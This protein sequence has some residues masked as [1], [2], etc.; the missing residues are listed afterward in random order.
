MVK[1]ADTR[2]QLPAS[3]HFEYI[4]LI[5]ELCDVSV[6]KNN[7]DIGSSR[8]RNPPGQGYGSY[9]SQPTID[10]KVNVAS[11]IEPSLRIGRCSF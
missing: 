7:R 9:T 10:P 1:V 11:Q 2:V 5:R 4:W 6:T 3:P 8:Q